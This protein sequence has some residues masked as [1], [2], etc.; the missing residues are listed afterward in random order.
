MKTLNKL[1]SSDNLQLE[2]R[3]ALDI[4]S[5]SKDKNYLRRFEVVKRF[6]AVYGVLP[7]LDQMVRDLPKKD[8][9]I[10]HVKVNDSLRDEI[11]HYETLLLNHP[12]EPEL[13]SK[14]D[15]LY[16]LEYRVEQN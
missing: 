15:S 16:D 5:E 9:I 14:L 7:K 3:L 6:I 10:S 8:K 4:L 11:T 2:E 12:G 13:I 1:Y